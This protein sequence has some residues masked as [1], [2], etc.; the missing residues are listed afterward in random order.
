[1]ITYIILAVTVAVS[2][3]CFNNYSLFNKL[4]YSPYRM[5]HSGEWYRIVTHG[6]VH[7][8]WTHLIVNMFTFLSFGVYVENWFTGLGFSGAS[9]LLLYFGGMIAASIYDL[10]KYRNNVYYTSIG[11]SGAVSAILFTAIFLNP[12]DKIYFFCDSSHS[13]YRFWFCLLVLLPHT[14]RNGAGITSITTPTST[15][16]CLVLSSRSCWNPGC[17]TCSCNNYCTG[18]FGN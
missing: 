6:F 17:L 4:S 1:M 14:W 13:R 8:D 11:A 15:V 18:R 16:P 5:T 9:F 7:A 2:I 3:A 10:W 12:W